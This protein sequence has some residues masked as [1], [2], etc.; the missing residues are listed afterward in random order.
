MARKQ[1]RGR[2]PTKVIP[3][4]K[5]LRTIPIPPHHPPPGQAPP[6]RFGKSQRTPGDPVAVP[7]PYPRFIPPPSTNL[8]NLSLDLNVILSDEAKAVQ[9]TGKLVFHSV[10]DTGGI[11]GDNVEKAIS[12]TMDKQ[13]SDAKAA[14]QPAPSFYYNLGDV[15]YFNGENKL[16]G[17]Q[18]YEPYQNYHAPI[19]AVAG[20][21]DGDTRTRPGDPV[22]TEPT[23]FGFMRNFCDSVSQNDSP[24]RPTQTQP[25]VYWTFNTPV[26]TI[27][28][29]YSNVDGTLDAR[30]TGEQQQWFEGQ[31]RDADPNKP[32]IVTVHHPPY[33]LDTTH[34]GYPDIGISIDRV[35]QA[36]NRIPTIVLSG[37]VHSY[38]RFERT[39]E[40]NTVPYIVSGGGGY[41][42]FAGLIHRIEKDAGGQPLPQG[43]QTNLP[44]VKLM[45][46]NDKEPGFLRITVDSKKK[47]LTSEYFLVPFDGSPSTL[48]DTVT[49]PW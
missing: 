28:G 24:Y 29:L 30:G 7:K 16:Y 26:A 39:L 17:S 8:N 3:L 20:N 5:V 35:I 37:H 42:N 19:F 32:L 38:Q 15:V 14:N 41:A 36:T 21:H 11:H 9:D 46:Y 6:H 34:G 33:S 10:G 23:L 40:S 1:S 47:T 31:V 25:Y 48:E 2:K 12:D 4:A 27:V 44:D 49:V 43:F 18:F 22:D 13:I 45:A